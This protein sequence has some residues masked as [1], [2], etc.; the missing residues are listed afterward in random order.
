M[1][2]YC[3]TRAAANFQDEDFKEETGIGDMLKRI[4]VK[5]RES[6]SGESNGESGWGK[7]YIFCAKSVNI[8]VKYG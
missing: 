7:F 4:L 3:G 2:K 8:Y 1:W 5:W 6:N